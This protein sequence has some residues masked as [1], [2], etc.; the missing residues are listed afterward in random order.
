MQNEYKNATQLP[1]LIKTSFPR[2]R[3]QRYNIFLKPP[4]KKW[5]FFEKSFLKRLPMLF[6]M[7][8]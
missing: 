2:L 4:N 6:K 1:P 8:S 5:I 7:H 3:V